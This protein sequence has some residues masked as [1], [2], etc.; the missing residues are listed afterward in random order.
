MFVVTARLVKPLPPDHALPTDHF[1]PPNR[2]EFF[3]EGKLEGSGHPD[4]PLTEAQ[5]LQ[6]PAAGAAQ[7]A[8]AQ[9]GAAPAG[10]FQLK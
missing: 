7:G 4:V 8:A 1:V 2:S 9:S 3:L 6:A 10:G 5:M